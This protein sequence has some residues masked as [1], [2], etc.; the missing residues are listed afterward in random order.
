[1]VNPMARFKLRQRSEII[2]TPLARLAGADDHAIPS[3]VHALLE[4]VEATF[5]PWQPALDGLA[6]SLDHEDQK[7]P[8]WVRLAAVI[9]PTIALWS[10]IA[11]LVRSMLSYVLFQADSA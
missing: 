7:F 8:G 5:G 3:P 6:Q 4:D 9:L 10:A 1:M 2:H 11:V